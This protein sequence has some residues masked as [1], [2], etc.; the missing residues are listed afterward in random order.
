L[1]DE[2]YFSGVQ[3]SHQ[4]FDFLIFEILKMLLRLNRLHFSSC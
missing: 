4:N 1:N 2:N 3:N